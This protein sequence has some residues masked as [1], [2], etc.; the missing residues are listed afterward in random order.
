[1]VGWCVTKLRLISRNS[2]GKNEETPSSKG[3]GRSVA[4]KRGFLHIKETPS[5]N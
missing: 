3:R 1:M 5:L 4:S 2:R